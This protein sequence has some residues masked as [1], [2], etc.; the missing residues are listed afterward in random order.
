MGNWW[1]PNCSDF[2]DIERYEK[3]VKERTNISGSIERVDRFATLWSNNIATVIAYYNGYYRVFL[4][5]YVKENDIVKVFPESYDCS[6]WG[7]SSRG[8]KAHNYLSDA[9]SEAGWLRS[10]LE[11][12]CNNQVNS[13][14]VLRV[15][16]R[17][18]DLKIPFKHVGIYLK[19]NRICHVYGYS[20][21]DK[22]MR[23][24][25]T[26]MSVFL[27]DTATTERYGNVEEFRPVIPFILNKNVIQ[28]IV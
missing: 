7:D 8:R 18:K 26:D 21:N 20:E 3:L 25:I 13:L 14:S 23:V 4:L 27:G 12:T 9:Q 22:D 2:K 15:E 11:S 28:K 24:Q 10:E 19:N 5:V 16:K 17:H 6:Y 1:C